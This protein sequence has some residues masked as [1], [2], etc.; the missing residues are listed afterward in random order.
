MNYMKKLFIYLVLLIHTAQL[1]SQEYREIENGLTVVA[2]KGL[3]LRNIPSKKGK[4]L[5]SVPFG[6]VV[7]PLENNDI[8]TKDTI[9][10]IK[11]EWIKVNHKK[12]E[13]YAFSPYLI[14][15]LTIDRAKP[16][17]EMII[18][19]EGLPSW[20][21]AYEPDFHYYGLYD[22]KDTLKWRKI[23][24]SFLVSTIDG[25]EKFED[26]HCV[27]D[28][29]NVKIATDQTEAS[30]VIVGSRNLLEE[31]KI[32]TLFESK[33]LGYNY[34]PHFLY[35]EQVISFEYNNATFNFRAFD[36]ISVDSKNKNIEKHYQI[37]FYTGY[38]YKLEYKNLQNIS[39]DLEL[40]GSGE[41][42]SFFKTPIFRWI[43]DLNGD[44]L[45]DA[46]VYQH[47][48]VEHG[49]THWENTLFLGKRINGN[50]ILQKVWNYLIGSCV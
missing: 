31:N 29:P 45:I 7:N 49:G 32:I 34:N 50:L 6:G 21:T 18:L 26:E 47:G 3:N 42:H 2:L 13:G 27:E 10:N 28:F 8:H 46:I 38:P 22:E 23:N 44:G 40:F 43:G 30:V 24:V 25:V 39:K 20:F 19:M 11:G 16:S 36:S 35:P 12:I 48:M 37:Q 15:N 1:L 33:N 14:G 41:K 17:D 4:V 9:D 5:M